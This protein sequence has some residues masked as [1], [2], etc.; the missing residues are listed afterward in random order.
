MAA[1]LFTNNNFFNKLS[2]SPPNLNPISQVLLE[3]MKFESVDNDA[4]ANN[5]RQWDINY[6]SAL[7]C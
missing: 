3:E 1:M 6:L 5:D 2:T 7:V 4:T